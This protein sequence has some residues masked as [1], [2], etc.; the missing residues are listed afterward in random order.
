[1]VFDRAI[2]E[3]HTKSEERRQAVCQKWQEHF[4]TWLIKQGAVVAGRATVASHFSFV[5]WSLF[6]LIV[7]KN[8]VRCFT[9]MDND[10]MIADLVLNYGLLIFP[11]T[12]APYIMP[13]CVL[14]K[15]D[16]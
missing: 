2:W 7:S 8:M 10:S 12:L 13:T 1:M 16:K 14:I 4:G 3:S 15:N 9:V 6:T 11:N 5:T